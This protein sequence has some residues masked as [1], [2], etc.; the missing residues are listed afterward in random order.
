MQK[1]ILFTV[2]ML[3]L[4]VPA[5]TKT[6]PATPIPIPV[7][8]EAIVD[9]VKMIVIDVSLPTDELLSTIDPFSDELKS[10]DD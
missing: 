5:C 2:I 3:M 7:G 9:G 4:I 1:R 8:S 10:A 6:P